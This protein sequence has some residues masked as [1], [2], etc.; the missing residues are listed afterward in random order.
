MESKNIVLDKPKYNLIKKV[1]MKFENK[2]Q[3]PK[4]KYLDYFLDDS[5]KNS[6]FLKLKMKDPK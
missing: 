4:K 2:K 1:N 5:F 3:L 6:Y